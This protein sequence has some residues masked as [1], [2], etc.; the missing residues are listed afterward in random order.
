MAHNKSPQRCMKL[1]GSPKKNTDAGIKINED[2]KRGGNPAAMQHYHN[3]PLML[4][5]SPGS[6]ENR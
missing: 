5:I 1:Q 4:K 3:E 6:P 2:I